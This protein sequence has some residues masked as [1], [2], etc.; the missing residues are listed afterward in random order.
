MDILN[1]LN[2]SQHL[3][4]LSRYYWCAHLTPLWEDILFPRAAST[5]TL[6][7]LRYLRAS[8]PKHKRSGKDQRRTFHPL[9]CVST[10]RINLQ[11]SIAEL[12]KFGRRNADLGDG[13]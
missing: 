1:A 13:T 8:C 12:E 11:G 4:A 6:P 7:G 3:A 2:V 9:R 5:E 10:R